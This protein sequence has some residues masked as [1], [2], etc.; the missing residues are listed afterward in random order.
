MLLTGGELTLLAFC[1]L[2]AVLGLGLR[3]A[4]SLVLTYQRLERIERM[5]FGPD[6]VARGTLQRAVPI[7]ASTIVIALALLPC[8]VLWG[9]AGLELIGP[10][11]AVILAGLPTMLFFAL[12]VLPS[13]YL[14]LGPR[15]AAEGDFEDLQKGEL[16]Q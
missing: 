11:A 13:L 9:R 7:L 5:P 6:L 15:A 14:A 12:F 10:T 16:Y 2:V 3:A 8:L 1:G 4:T